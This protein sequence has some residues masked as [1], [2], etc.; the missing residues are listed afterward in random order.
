[1]LRVRALQDV[2]IVELA[3]GL[4]VEGLGML[5]LGRLSVLEWWSAGLLMI[6]LGCVGGWTAA[7]AGWSR[8]DGVARAVLDSRVGA[9][10]AGLLL[11]QMAWATVWLSAPEI[12]YDAVYAKA[13]LPQMW[14]HTHSIGPLLDHPVLNVTGLAQFVAVAGHTLGSQDVGRELQMLMWVVLAATVWWWGRRSV[15]GPLAALAV[16]VV[17]QIVWQSATAFDDLMLTAG[18]VALAIA[19]L[20]TADGGDEERPLALA[21]AIGLLGGA[22]IWLK[23]NQLAVA[24]VLVAGWVVLSRPLRELPRRAGGVTLGGLVI[25]GPAFIVRWIDTGNPVFPSYNTIFKSPYYPLVDEQYNFPYWQG[26]GIWDA[27]KAPYETVVHPYLMNDSMPGGAM[28]LLAAA[29][30]IAVLVGWRH[31]GRRSVAIAW[32]ALVVGLLAWWVQFRYLRYALPTAMVGVLLVVTLMRGWRPGRIA[33]L[34][35]LAG[36]GLASAAYLPST[37]ASF[38]NVPYRNLPFAAAFGRWDKNDYLRTVFPEKDVLAAYQQ[39]ARPGSI[40]FSEAHERTFLEDRDLSPIWEVGRLLQAP[41]PL[42]TTGDAGLRALRR[43]GIGWAI[44]SDADPSHQVGWAAA[45]LAEHGQL[46]FADRGWGL[47]QLV[48]RPDRPRRLAASCDAL[49]RGIPDCWTGTFDDN[50][51]LADG[52]SPGGASRKIPVCPGE[53]IAVE[54]RTAAGGQPSHV[55]IDSD[56][57]SAMSGHQLVAIG[58]GATGTAYGTAPPGTRT[59]T[60]TLGPGIEGGKIASARIGT[61]GRCLGR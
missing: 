19:V 16:G 13:Y 24:I 41:G 23:L 39:L 17:P 51:G 43:L 61:L 45:V 58:P 11:L 15:V 31:R 8:R 40:A 20:R 35:L 47:Y 57:G 29:V 9:A 52:E 5:A 2:A 22:C 4:G 53:T 34:A 37:V 18:V 44:V 21:F 6:A 28:G 36:A 48:D 54:A 33:T 38:W 3:I 50:P 1:V 60:V 26:T 10:C 12:M 55:Y 42:P 56:S 25:A 32:L 46:M 30:A 14:A 7:C 49:L 59:M 27:L